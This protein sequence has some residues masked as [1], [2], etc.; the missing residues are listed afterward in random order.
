MKQNAVVVVLV[1]AVVALAVVVVRQRAEIADLKQAAPIALAKHIVPAERPAPA[2]LME[3]PS[4]SAETSPAAPTPA[5]ATGNT[6]SAGNF[7]SGLA[8]MM[9]NPQMKEMMRAQQKLM[10][11][12]TY[13]SLFKYLSTRP[14]AEVDALKQLLEDRQLALVDVG[15]AM[16]SGSTEDRKKAIEESK[17][18]KAEYDKKIQNLLGAEDYDVFKQYEATQGERMQVQMFKDALP[19]DAGLS[20]QQE[21][22]L[23]LMMAD[24]RKAFPASSLLNKGQNTDPSQMTEESINDALKQLE[25]LQKR[26]ADRAAAILTPA[27]LEQFTKFQQHWSKMSAAGLK[28]AQTMFGNKAAPPA[29]VPA[30]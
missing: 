26:Y 7:M 25:Q 11:D 1:V 16:M 6:N 27:Q 23:I 3:E 13:G 20:D 30:P 14:P 29:P 4:P 9:K 2:A 17:T 5:P 10:L 28:M 8:G 12:R 19:A 18:V 15:M 24:E 21:N 22:D